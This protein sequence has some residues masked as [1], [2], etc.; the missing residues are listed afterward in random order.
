MLGCCLCGPRLSPTPL[1]THPSTF[2]AGTTPLPRAGGW[3]FVFPPPLP[4]FLPRQDGLYDEGF[5]TAPKPSMGAA[6]V[7]DF[8][9]R[10]QERRI[11][12]NAADFM[13][14]LVSP[15]VPGRKPG[16]KCVYSGTG[17]GGGVGIK[18]WVRLLVV[19][20]STAPQWWGIAHV[21]P[22]SLLRSWRNW[23]GYHRRRGRECA[24]QGAAAA[25]PNDAA[26]VLHAAEPGPAGRPACG[27]RAR[28]LPHGAHL[29][30][31]GV[32][33]CVSNPAAACACLRRAP[34]HRVWLSVAL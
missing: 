28:R 3:V 34:A 27:Q 4:L 13:S 14:K 8:I 10:V 21:C 16:Q 12:P 22:F 20:V 6:L 32:D 33:W 15:D 9:N 29:G 2:P 23:G 11:E 5:L 18:A 1:R 31:G 24:V 17:E 25:A 30:S 19:D 26:A 7:Q